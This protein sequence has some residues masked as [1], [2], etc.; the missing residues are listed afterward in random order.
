MHIRKIES[1]LIVLVRFEEIPMLELLHPQG[2]NEVKELFSFS[3]AEPT[4]GGDGR[5]AFQFI[6]GKSI[7]DEKQVTINSIRVEDRKIIILVNG[8]SEEADIA[9]DQL[10]DLFSKMS[11]VEDDAFL[12]PKLIA[13]ESVI[14]A[15]INIAIEDLVNPNFL[16][17]VNHDVAEAAKSKIADAW[18]Q[19][20][21]L[22]FKI[23][24]E[25]SNRNLE[26]A[27]LGMSRKDF[28]I[29]P[30]AG[31]SLSEKIYVSAG[32]FDTDTHINLIQNFENSVNK[33][34]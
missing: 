33:S 31:Y 21:L 27:R 34:R 28:S 13:R 24:Y 20:D 12:E 16:K 9:W 18:S 4:Q 25:P 2:T 30:R 29:S 6:L 17:F 7:Q 15:N 26:E 3:G 1:K 5:P 22:L 10:R 14:V 11:K 23:S 32:P 19:L 8:T